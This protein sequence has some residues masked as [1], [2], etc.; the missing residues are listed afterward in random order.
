MGSPVGSEEV[1]YTDFKI[2][3]LKIL[4]EGAAKQEGWQDRGK[5]AMKERELRR[6][7]VYEGSCSMPAL[8]AHEFTIETMGF[9]SSPVGTAALAGEGGRE[10]DVNIGLGY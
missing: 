4:R 1:V 3:K 8:L 6:D 10:N 7:C 2:N 5:L 9:S